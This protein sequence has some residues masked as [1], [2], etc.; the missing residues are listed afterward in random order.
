MYNMQAIIQLENV[1]LDSDNTFT[2]EKLIIL[3]EYDWFFASVAHNGI[4]EANPY[5]VELREAF[6]CYLKGFGTLV[7]V[8]DDKKW[9]IFKEGFVQAFFESIYPLF[10]ENLEDLAK[11]AS[12]EGLMDPHDT[13]MWLP[14]YGLYALYTGESLMYV[15]NGTEGRLITLIS[16]VRDYVETNKKYYIGGCVEYND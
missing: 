8:S 13:D 14:L 1:P 9:V 3:D 4:D 12:L 16:F 11:N 10:Q 15:K 6:I 7:E 2:A 5:G